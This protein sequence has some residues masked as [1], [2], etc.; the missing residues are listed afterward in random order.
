[1]PFHAGRFFEVLD[2]MENHMGAI[3]TALAG[4]PDAINN[5]ASAIITKISQLEQQASAGVLDDADNT[6]IQA[7]KD[8]TANLAGIVS[9][10]PSD[11]PAPSAPVDPTASA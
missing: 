5:A 7:V 2:R 8:A 9:T 11:A 1:M 10:P 4:I 6:A 3:A